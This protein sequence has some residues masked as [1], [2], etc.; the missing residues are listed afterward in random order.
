MAVSLG[1]ETF[2]LSGNHRST[3]VLAPP[4][5]R[6]NNIFGG[7]DEQPAPVRRAAAPVPK[8][9][10]EVTF[11]KR[12]EV[13]TEH[14]GISEHSST[15]VHAAPG[16]R[17]SFNIFGGGADEAEAA[18]ARARAPTAPEPAAPAQMPAAGQRVVQRTE[19]SDLADKASTRV[20]APPGG[21]SSLGV[22]A[23]DRIAMMKERRAQTIAP[24]AEATN[25]GRPF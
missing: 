25:T 24:F 2:D 15:R 17:Q 16:G 18:P 3:R 14:T 23:A 4:G 7:S 19:H 10:E 1:H 9:A 6:T 11:G 13:R 12:I 5:G 8:P 20:H 21:A 22:S